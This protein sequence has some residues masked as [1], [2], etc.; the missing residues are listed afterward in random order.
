MNCSCC[1]AALSHEH[2][3]KEGLCEICNP[4]SAHYKKNHA[5]RPGHAG[6]DLDEEYYGL[7]GLTLPPAG[8]RH[9]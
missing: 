5:K 1:K 8:E 3:R 6:N 9:L 7:R 2:Q 4:R